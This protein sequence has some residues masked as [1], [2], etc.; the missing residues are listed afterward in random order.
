MQ[1]PHNPS[2]PGFLMIGDSLVAG[3]NWQ[4]RIPQWTI[5]NCGV[6]GLTTFELL[7]SLPRLRQYHPTAEFIMVMIG[8]NDLLMEEFSFTADL[9]KILAAL[10][11]TYMSTKIIV[12]TLLPMKIPYLAA[13]TIERTNERIRNIAD[14]TGVSLLD[15][16]RRFLGTNKRLFLEDG[17]HLTSEAYKIWTDSILEH[18]AFLGEND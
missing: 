7:Q 9:Q 17:V 11:K 13:E 14:L 2:A 1:T 16:H 4:R 12:N 6:P 15:I 10:V 5:H 8:T 3:C 18:I